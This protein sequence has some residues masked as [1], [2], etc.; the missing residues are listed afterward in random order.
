MEVTC[1]GLPVFWING[2]LAAV[3]ATVLDDRI[4]LHWT[5]GDHLA[6]LSAA[7]YDPVEALVESWPKQELLEDLPI[8]EQW[9]GAGVLERKVKVDSFRQR[10]RAA[11]G[12][13][14][15]WTLSSTMTDLSVDKNREVAHARFDPV[16]PGSIKS[17][18][19]R[20]LKVH[21]YVEKPSSER[22][23][24]SLAGE[25]PRVQDNGLGFDPARLG[26]QADKSKVYTEPV[27]EVMAFF[28]LKLLPMRGRGVDSSF[29]AE[30]F[31][32]G[33][34]QRGWSQ[35]A[36]RFCWPAWDQPLDVHGIDALLD[37]WNPKD[38]KNR[39]SALGVH[40]AWQ[41]VKYKALSTSDPTRAY[42]SERL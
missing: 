9:Q 31:G 20:L 12:H 8:A 14:R 22:I 10:A 18:H 28:G 25:E 41:S 23:R 37:L 40:A 42:G 15:S 5:T 38:K 6:I 26:S 35:G 11:R 19:H 27:V 34:R 3:G 17:L 29:A 24:A 1:Q 2:W 39:W 7:D 36:P 4:R 16:G 21:K 30:A 33:G 32:G 13:P